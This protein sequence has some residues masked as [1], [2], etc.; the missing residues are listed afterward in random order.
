[1]A[2]NHPGRGHWTL[3]TCLYAASDHC[4]IV[5]P[6]IL[7]SSD[8]FAATPWPWPR[9]GRRKKGFK[10]MWKVIRNICNNCAS[11]TLLHS[12]VFLPIHIFLLAFQQNIYWL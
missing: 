9:K 12:T 3:D 10:S 5:C 4:Y 6:M 8:E 1:M 11:T 7:G 2:K